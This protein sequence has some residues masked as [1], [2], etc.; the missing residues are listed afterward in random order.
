MKLA[1]LYTVFNGLDLL[2]LSIKQIYNEVDYIVI[3]YQHISNTG[4]RNP[5]LMPE[6]RGISGVPKVILVEFTPEM[7]VNTKENERKK[8]NLM[9]Y[10]A[11]RLKC[12]HFF[13]AA[14]DHF[15]EER[16][17]IRAKK[18]CFLND[19]DVTFT[20]M[21]TYFKYPEWQLTPKEEYFM[22]FIC[23]LYDNTAVERIPGYPLYTDPS[24]QVNTFTKWYLFEPEEISLHHYTMI[25]NDIE[26]KFRNAAASIR[27]NP[28]QVKRFISEFKN[29]DIELNPGIEYFNGRKIKLV[30]NYF[31]I[32]I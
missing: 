6:L 28:E 8:H 5:L 1:A 25:R 13:L 4:G 32:K 10:T 18:L 17:V 24:V 29:Y 16:Q 20:S 12:S 19:F 9:I 21:Y 27:W 7:G 2:E 11:K 14:C 30:D 23:K 31:G 15:Y 22:P 3:C 26:E